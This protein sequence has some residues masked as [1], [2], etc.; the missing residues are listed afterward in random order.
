MIKRTVS[1]L[2]AVFMLLA[3]TGCE[4]KHEWIEASCENPKTCIKCEATE[5]EARGHEYGAWS[6]EDEEMSHVCRYCSVSET[7]DIDREI[8]L[9]H[10]LRGQW[11][12]W[13]VVDEEL[14]LILHPAT[15]LPDD[16]I[17]FYAIF[18][19]DGSG[20]Y[21]DMD[22]SNMFEIEFDEYDSNS[23]GEFYYFYLVWKDN[24]KSI[25]MLE[26]SDI[27][28]I[29]FPL[30]DEYL[31]LAKDSAFDSALIGRWEDDTG[32]LQLNAD[33]SFTADMGREFNGTWIPIPPY[34]NSSR[35]GCLWGIYLV[36]TENGEIRTD[37]WIN[38]TDNAPHD[39]ATIGRLGF[40]I[41]GD[42]HILFPVEN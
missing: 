16:R 38:I 3:L 15:D 36:Y 1:L 8:Y 11:D 2:M 25:M 24:S 7:R 12:F 31:L 27:T 23:Q 33:R 13:G 34:Y 10:L 20:E 40:E 6:F 29:W 32:W 26:V 21:Y 37:K 22:D 35:N 28:R 9:K 4:C 39:K 19:A 42:G 41:N 14:D 17:G 5:G 30:A 18:R